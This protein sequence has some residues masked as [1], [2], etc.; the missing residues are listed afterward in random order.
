[1]QVLF[2]KKKA[3]GCPSPGALPHPH[4]RTED[5]CSYGPRLLIFSSGL[6]PR[7]HFLQGARIPNV[8]TEKSFRCGISFN[9]RLSSVY[10]R[11]LIFFLEC[12]EILVNTGVGRELAPY[13]GEPSTCQF[14][15]R[16]CTMTGLIVCCFQKTSQFVITLPASSVPTIHSASLPP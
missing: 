6:P 4:R 2:N 3:P 12:Q 11:Y 9:R 8:S 7:A 14:L 10:T 13:R 15:G 16:I 1:M 5:R